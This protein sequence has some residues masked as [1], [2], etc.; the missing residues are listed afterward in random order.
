M[1]RRVKVGAVAGSVRHVGGIVSA[2]QNRFSNCVPH[3]SQWRAVVIACVWAFIGLPNADAQPS[4]TVRVRDLSGQMHAGELVEISAAR[5]R[6]GGKTPLEWKRADVLRVDWSAQPEALLDDC[7]QLLL[8]NGDRLGIR[9]VTIDEAALRGNWQRFPAWPEIS[10]PLETLRGVLLI[11]PRNPLER[12]Q[13]IVRLREQRETKDIFYL[14]NG[15]LLLGQ[16]DRFENNVFGL[17]AATGKLTVPGATVRGFGMNPELTSFP[18]AKGNQ[19]LVTLSDGSLLTLGDVSFGEQ[20]TLR[21]RAAFGLDLELPAESVVSLQFLGGRIV[22][23]SDIEPTEYAFTPYLTRKWP[24]R[25]NQNAVGGPLRL[26]GREYARG[27]GM[28]SQSL[29]TYRLNGEF[30]VFQAM[31]GIDA[32]TEGEGSV[33]FRVLAD[34]KPLFTSN[35]VRGKTPALALGPLNVTD[36][37]QLTLAVDFADHGDILDHAD[38]CDALLIKRESP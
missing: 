33:V 16:L 18:P 37:Q 21:G 30:A 7:P 10:V 38:W 13:A 31:I 28:H 14:S 4:N 35:V 34:G 17:T 15:D 29:A 20:H 36:V 1:K 32:V 22:Y 11:P 5:V 3:G 9:P 19:S 12:S 24:L 6:L 2:V 27:I 25:S 26:G 23:L 8:A